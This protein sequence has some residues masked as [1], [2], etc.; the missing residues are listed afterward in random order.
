VKSKI[1]IKLSSKKIKL[2]TKYKPEE[3][4]IC[5][6]YSSKAMQVSTQIIKEIEKKIGFFPSFLAPAIATPQVLDSLWQQTLS[7]YINNPLPSLFKEKVF[8]YL[9]Q[10]CSVPYFLICHSCVLR[11]LGMTAKEIFNLIQ[12]SSPKN[13]S[14]LRSELNTLTLTPIQQHYWQSNS[15]IEDSLLRCSIHMFLQPSQ[16]ESCRMQLRQ[17]LGMSMYGHLIGFLGYIKVCHQWLESNPEISYQQ[18]RRAQ[19]H[20]APLLLEEFELAEY[21]Q[22]YCGE[23]PRNLLLASTNSN[24]VKI[25]ELP[26]VENFVSLCQER[27][28]TCFT[29]APFPM[30]IHDSEGDILHINQSWIELTGYTVRDLPTLNAWTQQ[31][32]VQRQDIVHSRNVLLEGE[33]AFQKVV[34]SLLDIP[35]DINVAK[36]EDRS[37]AIIT[38]RSEVKIVT[39]QGERRIWDF[40]STLLAK[41]SDGREITIA[42]AKDITNCI[43]TEAALTE[44]ELRFQLLLEA[45]QTGT[46]EWDFQTNMVKVC[47]RTRQILG[48]V[49]NE[50]HYT[51]ESFL[52]CIHPNERE[53]IDLGIARTVRNRQD[54]NTKYRI[55]RSDGEINWVGVKGKLVYDE[56]GNPI[57]MTGVILELKGNKKNSSRL[58]SVNYEHDRSPEELESLIDAIP[59]YIFVVD[60]KEMRVS[61]CNKTFAKGIGLRDREQVKGKNLYEC[62][63]N[64]LAKYIYRHNQQVI[65]TGKTIQKLETIT[66][67]DGRHYF[68]TQKIPLKNADGEVYSVIVTFRNISEL[69]ATKKALSQRTIE[70]DATNRELECFSYSV[71]HDLHAPLRVINGFS[72]ILL[73]RYTDKLDEKG[74]H[75]LDRIRANSEHMGELIDDLLKL[76][77]ITRSQINRTKVNLSAIAKKLAIELSL[78][79]PE[80]MVEFAIAPGLLA[81]GDEKLIQILIDN[82]LNN[83]WKYTSKH[84]KA[85]IE[86]GAIASGKDNKLTYFIK[87]NGAGF[88]MAYADKLFGAFQRLHSEADFP[89]TGIGL[90]TV[91]RIVHKHGGK[92]WAEGNLAQGATFYFTL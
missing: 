77:R 59:Y 34:H 85:R 26:R 33:S 81:K 90:A 74:K 16:A 9:S 28:R 72:Q 2:N 63:P 12:L 13:E 87:D 29:N 48:L 84:P 8:A 18:D 50:W 44:M 17:F 61:F 1:N 68:E 70:L 27:F 83:A 88:D 75:Y 41:F 80:R 19:L 56:H 62:F 20:L 91:K 49:S 22:N 39:S 36:V 64:D 66:L 31:A 46:W 82:L 57:R 54:L 23:Q 25:E 30:M 47:P 7:A 43:R 5:S 3:K 38:T 11:S 4:S 58:S 78:S 52:Q 92:V 89:G 37:E 51:Y 45:T 14:D 32:Q 76:S 10:Y 35:Y 60:S 6:Q 86:F 71:S 73:E 65:D 24:S 53:S 79:Q 42:M 69:V 55:T 40:Y 15:A 67:A 21:F